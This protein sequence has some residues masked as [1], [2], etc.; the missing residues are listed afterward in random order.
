MG[1]APTICKETPTTYKGPYPL[2]FLF[3]SFFA[4]HQYL[5]P[6]QVRGA[7]DG[8]LVELDGGE[9]SLEEAL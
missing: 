6:L 4:H 3:L 8:S 2:N 9:V 7:H 1:T 5:D